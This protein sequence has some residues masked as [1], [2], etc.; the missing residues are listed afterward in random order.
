VFVVGRNDNADWLV[1]AYHPRTG[2]LLWEQTYHLADAALPDVFDA[3][4]QVATDGRRLVVAGYGSHGPDVV[5]RES[6]D[7]VVN[8]YD[9]KTGELLWSDVLDLAG[10]L[11]EAVGGVTFHRGQIFAYGVVTGVAGGSDLL[12][13]AYDPRSGQVLWQDQV[14]KSEFDEW[15][16]G[17]WLKSLAADYGRV[18][19]VGAS[20]IR[21]SDGRR[22]YDWIVR[23]YD[24]GGGED[25]DGDEDDKEDDGND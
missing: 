15:P 16:A 19:I 7:W 5:S 20:V 22:N 12:I 21:H 24:A 3:A 23:T 11:D 13:R 2:T 4:F 14:N 17:I 25:D 8:T 1:R 6:R 9:A 10:R 18:T